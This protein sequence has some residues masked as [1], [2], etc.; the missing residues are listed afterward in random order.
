[1]P[2]STKMTWKEVIG[3]RTNGVELIGG[4]PCQLTD[5]QR[6]AWDDFIEKTTEWTRLREVETE[7]NVLN[8]MQDANDAGAY[9]GFLRERHRL[10]DALYEIGRKWHAELMA[11]EIDTSEL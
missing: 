4:F 8:F 1:M 11:T 3:I 2:D 7:I 5:D 6:V 10:L 9:R